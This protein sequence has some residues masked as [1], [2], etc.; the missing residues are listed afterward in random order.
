M[1]RPKIKKPRVYFSTR[2]LY[3]DLRD[4][5]RIVS[6]KYG[7]TMEWTLNVALAKGLR[8]MEEAIPTLGTKPKPTAEADGHMPSD[9]P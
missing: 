6:E 7:G 9:A 1:R 4:R 2:N 3:K 5:M 8:Q